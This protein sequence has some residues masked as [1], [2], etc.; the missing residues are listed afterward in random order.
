[1]QAPKNPTSSTPSSM[2]RSGTHVEK[3]GIP[4]AR[5][6]KYRNKYGY[7]SRARSIIEPR[8]QVLMPWKSRSVEGLMHVKLAVAHISHVGVIWKW[9]SGIICQVPSVI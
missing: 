5:G 7:K 2:D 9:I 4:C 1:M 6:L 8:I 3:V